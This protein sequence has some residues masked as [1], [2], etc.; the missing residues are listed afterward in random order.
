MQHPT[1]FILVGIPGSGK[2]YLARQLSQKLGIS[3]VSAEQIRSTIL[4]QPSLS[5]SEEKLVRRIAM[6]LIE[7]MLRL[8]MSMIC[9]IPSSRS[10]QRSELEKLARHHKFQTVTIY[11]QIDKQA[12]WLRCRSR[13]SQQVDDR[14]ATDLDEKTFNGLCDKLQAPVGDRVIVVAGSH[15]FNSQAQTILRR[16]LEMQT[17]PADTTLVKDIPKP[18]LI[19]LVA[20]QKPKPLGSPLNIALKKGK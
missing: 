2:T 17:L 10:S 11:Q 7:E 19:N 14:Y 5:R 18:G 9:D 12:A 6:F 1:L 20:S 8:G 16:L 4:D 15:D 3:R 13:H